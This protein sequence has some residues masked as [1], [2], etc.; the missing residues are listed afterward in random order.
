M[1]EHTDNDSPKA[2]E[3]TVSEQ[4]Y[5]P[6]STETEGSVPESNNETSQQDDVV[7]ENAEEASKL[8]ENKTDEANEESEENTDKEATESVEVEQFEELKKTK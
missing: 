1:L 4:T 3:E 5:N 7:V 2:N 8:A 6:I